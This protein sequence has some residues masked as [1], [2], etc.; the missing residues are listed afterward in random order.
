MKLDKW[1]PDASRKTSSSPTSNQNLSV[2]FKD[3]GPAPSCVSSALTVVGSAASSVESAELS[4]AKAFDGIVTPT[5]GGTNRWS[6]LF[7]DPQWIYADL[8][9]NRHLSA[10]VLHWECAYA[11][12]YDLQVAPSGADP[13]SAAAY[14][15]VFTNNASAGGSQ[16]IAGLDVAARYVRVYSRA[17]ATPW[18]NSLFE[19]EIKGDANPNC[20][21]APTPICG[22]GLL[23]QGEA[24]DDGNKSNLDACTNAC[25][26]PGCG[27]ALCSASES[28]LACAV[29]CGPCPGRSIADNLQAETHD[30]MF[31][32]LYETTTDTGGG[33]NAGWIASGDYVQWLINVPTTGAY[34]VTT[35]SATWAAAGQQVLVDGVATATLSLPRTWTGAGARYQTWASF[36]TA[37]FNLTAG[38][39]TLRLLFTSGNQN[40]NWVKVSAAETNLLTN[41]TF[42]GDLN[43]WLSYFQPPFGSAVF[44]PG[45]AR[46]TPVSSG[47]DWWAQFFQSRTV[48]A[49]NYKLTASAQTLTG[50]KTIALFCEQDGGAYTGY[51][52]TNCNLTTAWATCSVTC[53]NVPANVAVKFGAKGGLSN[54]AF[55]LDNLVLTKLN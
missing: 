38:A 7:A 20:N 26:L 17:R 45:T 34:T 31:G 27:D 41:G 32:L 46:I 14:T 12:D 6:S 29:D 49:G 35:R 8:G 39:H 19:V 13:T 50:T 54:R 55:R 30:G 42:A 10:V 21:A 4:A 9:A 43:G 2:L 51:G 28:C 23:E 11:S 24:C 40:L 53:N 16:T 5:C 3:I 22:N 37:S 33:L 36:P 18:G 25:A 1:V 47:T 15:T 44:D 48:A 52:Q